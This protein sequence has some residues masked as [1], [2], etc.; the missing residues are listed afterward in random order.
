[1]ETSKEERQGGCKQQTTGARA[2]VD[3]LLCPQVSFCFV[4]K[5]WEGVDFNPGFQKTKPAM[6]AYLRV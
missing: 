5:Q 1:M 3:S 4:F 6:F 2:Q